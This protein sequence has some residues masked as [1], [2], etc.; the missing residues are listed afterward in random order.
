MAKENKSP[1][2]TI[3]IMMIITLLGK[4]SGLL[5]DRLLTINYG[6]GMEAN[7]FL[8]ASR[9]P[10]VFFDAVFASAITA[11]FIPVFNEYMM[12]N[13]KKDAYKFSG[14]FITVI[15]A[16][17]LILTVLGI[18]FSDQLTSLFAGGFDSETAALCSFLTKIMFPTVLFTGLAF[19]FVGILQS[20]G[21]FNLPAAMSLI[22]NTFIII[23]YFT[24]N[25]RF[26]IVG[27]AIAFSIAWLLQ[28]LT[29]IPSLVKR[30]FFFKPSLSI[31]NPGMQKVFVLM[32]P[33][34]VSTWVTPLNQTINARFGSELFGGAGVSAI[35]LAYNLYTII[36][37]VFILSITNYIFPK[38][39]QLNAD[40]NEKGMKDV[41]SSTMHISMYAVI[42]MMAGLMVMSSQVINFIY[43]GGEFD[44][45]SVQITSRAL[46]FLTLG[47]IGY[48][49]QAVLTRAFFAEQEGRVPLIAGL[50]SI[51]V[52]VLLSFALVDR[53]DVAGLGFASAA[54][55]TVNGIVLIIAIEKG[56]MGFINK[57]FLSDMAKIALSTVI[58]VVMVKFISGVLPVSAGKLMQLCVPIAAG[59][60]VYIAA[61]ALLKVWETEFAFNFIK[62]K[63]LRR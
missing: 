33:V 45:F 31:R 5:R 42:P 35:E 25:K 14:N 10:R 40:R 21:E 47:M 26:G 63:I 53:F 58:M 55:C 50:A 46:F 52:N 61:T 56:K 29:Q 38:L 36:V 7:A 49:V 9:I 48:A 34:M 1:V 44:E 22:S 16:F 30:E 39:S 23:Y 37:G 18:I 32:V 19:S 28:A 62:E 27:L 2:K 17:S 41:I 57:K 12:R 15:S 43:G 20:M 11:S 51:V 3:S 60:V 8:T 59:V 6:T 24:F 54:S 4:I 13:G